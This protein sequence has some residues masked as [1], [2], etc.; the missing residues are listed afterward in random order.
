MM[1]FTALAEEYRRH[2]ESLLTEYPELAEDKETLIDTLD[3]LTSLTDVVSRFIRDALDDESLAEALSLR[4]K[5]M[6]ERRSRIQARADKRRAIALSLMNAVEM[7]KVEAPEFT[8]SVGIAQPKVVITDESLLPDAYVRITR[9]PD[10][11]ALRDRL[12]EG[13]EIPG[14]CLGN[15]H[16]T[17]RVRTK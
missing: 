5:E 16:A 17:L 9:A 8:A 1:N 4:L 11:L 3:G 10:K 6:G 7:P 2:R 13:S 14:A 15:G 12:M